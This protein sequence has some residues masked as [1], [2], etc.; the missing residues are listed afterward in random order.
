MAA[1]RQW[2]ECSGSALRQCGSGGSVAAVLCGS[3]AVERQCGCNGSGGSVYS[4]SGGAAAVLFGSCS[5][6]SAVRQCSA[7]V[8][9]VAAVLRQV[10]VRFA[11]EL[12][13]SGRREMRMRKMCF[14]AVLYTAPR[15]I[16][17]TVLTSHH[18][19]VSTMFQWSQEMCKSLKRNTRQ[20]VVTLAS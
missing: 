4:C 3:A 7:A 1:V 13:Y 18:P 2:S 6:G 14:R 12:L 16:G 5:G 19:K 9:A 17:Y 11:Q 20:V 15:K 8:A 10:L